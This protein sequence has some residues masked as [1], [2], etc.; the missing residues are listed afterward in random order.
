M[1]HDPAIYRHLPTFAVLGQNWEVWLP[2]TDFQS[3]SVGINNERIIMHPGPLIPGSN[4]ILG[5]RS[6][7][8]SPIRVQASI[9]AA[10]QGDCPAPANGIAWSLDQGARTLRSGTLAAGAQ[11][12]FELPLLRVTSGESLY[13]VVEDDGDTSNCDSTFVQ[14]VIETVVQ[15]RRCSEQRHS[16]EKL[17]PR[18]DRHH[19]EKATFTNDS[20]IGPA[21]DGTYP[22]TFLRSATA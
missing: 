6:P 3:A 7:V 19:E 8:S 12:S 14:L 21:G 18:R 17:R 1:A 11:A 13:V 2:L 5:W 22:V 9:A 15:A 4:A 16:P 20:P 10:P